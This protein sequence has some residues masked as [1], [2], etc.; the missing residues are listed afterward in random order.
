[1]PWRRSRPTSYR[2]QLAALR[3]LAKQR[4][5]Y[6]RHQHH[7]AGEQVAATGAS[8]WWS[9]DEAVVAGIVPCGPSVCCLVARAGC[10]R[11][12]ARDMPKGLCWS[13]CCADSVRGCPCDPAAG[14]PRA[15]TYSGRRRCGEPYLAVFTQVRGHL[16]V[17]VR[18]YCKTVGSAY[19]GSNPTPATTCENGPL[20]AE[21]R[22]WGRLLL[23]TPA[24]QHVS[25]P[26][27]VLRCP[28]TYSG[29]RPG[30]QDGRC[31]PSAVLRTAT[32]G[33]CWRAF[34][35]LTC[36]AE[37]GVHPRVPARPGPPM[38]G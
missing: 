34:P 11:S 14:S 8:R 12:R 30:R 13:A 3:L 19:V 10:G 1:M 7:P 23:V 18:E 37:P 32:D 24:Y 22:L 38:R 35:G 27:D 25:L 16:E 9:C 26:V 2:F 6:H 21:T 20:A 15:R 36:A 4:H 17:Q 29:R 28:R 5:G 31:A 33:P